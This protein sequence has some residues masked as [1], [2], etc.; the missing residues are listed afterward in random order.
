MQLYNKIM[1]GINKY[2]ILCLLSLSAMHRNP[3]MH[4]V[5]MQL[6]NKH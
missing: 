6:Q 4:S 3:T 5:C 2:D 1:H